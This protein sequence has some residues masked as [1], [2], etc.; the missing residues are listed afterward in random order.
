MHSY[1]RVSASNDGSISEPPPESNFVRS[2]FLNQVG[3]YMDRYNS[4]DWYWCY[5]ANLTLETPKAI[6]NRHL[7]TVDPASIHS[8][9]LSGESAILMRPSASDDEKT[10]GEWLIVE[11]RAVAND[12]IFDLVVMDIPSSACRSD[13]YQKF[14]ST[15]RSIIEST[16]LARN[17][18]ERLSVWLDYE[19]WTDVLVWWKGRDGFLDWV[20]PTFLGHLKTQGVPVKIIQQLDALG[21]DNRLALTRLING[22]LGLTLEDDIAEV[23]PPIRKILEMFAVREHLMEIIDSGDESII[24][25]DNLNLILSQIEDPFIQA[26]Y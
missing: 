7:D 14:L 2:S 3:L 26:I 23:T 11:K 19:T 22:K 16:D 25:K 13:R 17:K 5:F 6:L 20:T 10:Y 15:F 1:N 4:I 9:G 24:E 21:I 18:R 8:E 12:E